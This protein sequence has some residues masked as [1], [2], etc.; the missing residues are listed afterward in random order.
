MKRALKLSVASGLVMVLLSPVSTAATPAGAASPGAATWTTS[1]QRPSANFSPN[2]SEQGFTNHTVRQVVRV[3][4]G[5]AWARAARRRGGARPLPPARPL[6]A[7]PNAA[8]PPLPRGAV[9][10]RVPPPPLPAGPGD[11]APAPGPPPLT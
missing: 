4:A 3:R 10:R 5:G 9:P 11:P 8:R 6:S 1:L 7:P 2:W